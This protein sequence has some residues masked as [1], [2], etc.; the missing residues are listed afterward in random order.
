[1]SKL[2][3]GMINELLV[4]RGKDIDAVI[5][6]NIQTT[7]NFNT[8]VI[9]PNCLT[10]L[11]ML[12]VKKKPSEGFIKNCYEQ[13]NYDNKARKNALIED[14]RN[15][16]NDFDDKEFKKEHKQSS[17]LEK[18]IDAIEEDRNGFKAK[19]GNDIFVKSLKN[20][21]EVIPNESFT[22]QLLSALSEAKIKAT[23]DKDVDQIVE[24]EKECKPMVYYALS[25]FD[26][27]KNQEEVQNRV[28]Q[29]FNSK[30]KK[31]AAEAYDYFRMLSIQNIVKT[32]LANESY[33][34][35]NVED[36]NNENSLVYIDVFGFQS[37]LINKDD[38][39]VEQ[40]LEAFSNEGSAGF[41]TE[42]ENYRITD[43]IKKCTYFEN[44]K[45]SHNSK[46]IQKTLFL[47]NDKVNQF[48]NS[49]DKT[50][51]SIQNKENFLQT[52][53]AFMLLHDSLNVKDDLDYI[54]VA[55]AN[56]ISD[57]L[58]L[59]KES[60]KE[61]DRLIMNGY[62][63]A[64]RIVKNELGTS[65]N[66]KYFKQIT[67]QL[68]E[69]GVSQDELS[70][71]AEVKIPNY[72]RANIR[73]YKTISKK[74][75][76]SL[77]KQQLELST[78]EEKLETYHQMKEQK[79]KAKALTK[80]EK[81]KLIN[82]QQVYGDSNNIEDMINEIKISYS[83]MDLLTNKMVSAIKKGTEFELN[84][85]TKQAMHLNKSYQKNAERLNQYLAYF[86]LVKANDNTKKLNVANIKEHIKNNPESPLCKYFVYL[87]DVKVK[88]ASKVDENIT[89][90]IENENLIG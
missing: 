90:N 30:G 35:T 14:A 59:M 73:F 11:F 86:E 18:F 36:T 39:E 63:I 74:I 33:L 21:E 7:R 88:K 17:N 41:V 81:E 24:I 27:F 53:I 5:M 48:N 66:D 77:S 50:A 64:N 57:I 58:S 79:L 37:F 61:V 80:K 72:V 8:K 34:N 43:L 60:P 71:N 70:E 47:I 76:A 68:E 42:N 1:M 4:N 78:L 75:I 38:P 89:N 9:Q 87:P 10:S 31:D 65:L 85:K 40:Y 44:G 26:K 67:T 28:I 19:Y 6:D 51:T 55:L 25:K 22:V 49:T 46:Y 56:P 3:N 15:L 13:E 84:D 54:G 29:Y 62:K 23:N 20:V 12:D 32:K 69:K 45:L 16:D 2:I 52:A 82:M 83:D